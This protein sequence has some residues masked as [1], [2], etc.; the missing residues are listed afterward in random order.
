MSGS[1]I[2]K[3]VEID[4]EQAWLEKSGENSCLARFCMSDFLCYR[5]W[6]SSEPSSL[7]PPP[8]Q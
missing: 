2:E 3:E 5:V 4:P 7:Y 6:G 1:L 8:G